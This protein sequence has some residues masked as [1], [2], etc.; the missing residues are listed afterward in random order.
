MDTKFKQVHYHSKLQQ[1]N[2]KKRETTQWIQSSN[3]FILKKEN[4]DLMNAEFQ[5]VNLKKGERSGK[6]NIPHVFTCVLCIPPKTEV[7]WYLW[8]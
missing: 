5:L 6:H 8:S 2:L 1:V 3:R 7:H 4:K